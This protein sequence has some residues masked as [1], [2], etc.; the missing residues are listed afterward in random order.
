MVNVSTKQI[1]LP[2][3]KF[4]TVDEDMY[5]ILSKHKWCCN[6]KGYVF[7]WVKNEK[8]GKYKPSYMQKEIMETKKGQIVY[9]K[10]R[11]LLKLTR[12]NLLVTSR[13]DLSHHVRKNTTESEYMGVYLNK[14]T[15]KYLSY[16]T[17][18]GQLYYLGSFNEKRD[19][20]LVRDFYSRKYYGDKA[21]INVTDESLT[22]EDEVKKLV[23]KSSNKKTGY[24]GV[25]QVTKNLYRARLRHKGID[26]DFGLHRS[27]IEAAKARDKEILR[28]GLNVKK[29]NFISVSLHTNE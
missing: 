18:E 17:Y 20:A 8:N 27:A 24:H 16:I 21:H 25:T 3:N 26:Y 4:V 28:L 5:E 9:V 1:P 22:S 7:R 23:A 13:R 2:N 29:M 10:D 19:A 6:S 11:N 14:V 15:N 12:E